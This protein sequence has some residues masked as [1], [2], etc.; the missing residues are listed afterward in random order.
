MRILFLGDNHAKEL[1]D[2]LEQQGE[3]VVYSED[4]INADRLKQI[5]PDLIVS[6]NYKHIISTEVM[7]SV[8]GRAINLHISYLPY[9]RGAHPNIWSFLENTPKG[10]TIHYID[11]GIDTGDIIL[12]KE[13]YIDEDK[14]TLKSSYEILHN[15]IQALFKK[16]WGKI[17]NNE[18]I[19]RVQTG[20]S[21]IHFKR[22]M[23]KFEQFLSGKGW[24]ISIK[25]FKKQFNKPK[26]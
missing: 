17:K 16:N 7:R 5:L 3:K 19:P 10:V 8:N 12:Q 9:N 20:E 13:V 18:I 1:A 15:E 24:D 14:E 6:Y 22:E 2:W 23:S 21:S 25:E 26:D 4:K 11:E